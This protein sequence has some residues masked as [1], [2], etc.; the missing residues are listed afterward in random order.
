MSVEIMAEV[1][2]GFEGN[3][4][5]TELLTKAALE[6]GADSIKFQMIYADELA[7]P[8]YQFYDLYKSLEMDFEV[9]AKTADEIHKH[10]KK[11]YFNVI[12]DKSMSVAKELKADGVK[13][14]TSGFYDRHFIRKVLETFPYLYL[15]VGGIPVEDIESLVQD[16]LGDYSNKVCLQYGI[17]SEP[18]PLEA[19]N[20]RKITSLK[21]KFPQ[22]AIGF[23]DHA[24]GELEDKW[25]LSMMAL[26]LEVS[27]IEK[28]ITLDRVLKVEDYISGLEPRE[29][30]EYVRL[31][32]KFES[33]LGDPSLELS[34]EEK[35]YRKK[36][37]K[38]VVSNQDLLA[39]TG[40]MLDHV[41]LK[42]TGTMEQDVGIHQLEEVLG[43][44]LQRSIQK[45]IPITEDYL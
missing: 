45:N 36:S 43:K 38:K 24:D 40:L 15:G 13:I 20:L 1:A 18:T 21:R 16:I 4:K 10:G 27:C 39:G 25:Y 2:Q 3:L 22:F 26:S 31:M 41:S 19:N 11:L 37:V 9:W 33:A 44:T 28:H 42:R 29:F 17:Q 30:K 5:L 34:Y 8:D 7:T 35:T 23:M 12:G 32:K 14:P 6:A